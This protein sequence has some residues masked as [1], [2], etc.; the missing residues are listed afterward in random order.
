MLREFA[1][2]DGNLWFLRMDVCIPL[3]IFAVGNK[4][5]KVNDLISCEHICIIFNKQNTYKVVSSIIYHYRI[6]PLLLFFSSCLFFFFDDLQC[7]LNRFSYTICHRTLPIVVI[8]RQERASKKLV[9]VLSSHLQ[10][11]D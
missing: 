1:I 10:K 8:Q 3:D 2:V 6:I 11:Q 7:L 9:V 4:D 5:G